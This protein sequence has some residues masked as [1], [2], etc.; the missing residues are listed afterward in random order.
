MLTVT[1]SARFPQHMTVKRHLRTVLHSWP[2]SSSIIVSVTK[3]TCNQQWKLQWSLPKHHR[4]NCYHKRT[5]CLFTNTCCLNSLAGNIKNCFFFHDA[6]AAVG[7]WPLLC[8]G[9]TITLRHTTLGR[10]PLEEWS[11]RRRDL[12]LTRHNT[13]KRQA[14]LPAARSK[15]AKP[16]S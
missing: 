7:P 5:V 12:Y 16:A 6:T 2:Y 9:S 4:Q 14:T 10:I 15:S 11:A 8:W 13:H 1:Y 3:I